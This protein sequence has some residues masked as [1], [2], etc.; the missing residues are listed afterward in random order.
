VPESFVVD[1]EGKVRYYFI[2]KRDWDSGI[3]ETCLRSV[4]EE[5]S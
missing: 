3:S 1:R 2:N 4:V 5:A